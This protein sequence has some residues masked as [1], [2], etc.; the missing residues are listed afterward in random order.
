M[1]DCYELA[2]I[3]PA[4]TDKEERWPMIAK[5]VDDRLADTAHEKAAKGPLRTGDHP[6]DS[7]YRRRCRQ[8]AAARLARRQPPLDARLTAMDAETNRG[9]RGAATEKKNTD[10]IRREPPLL[11]LTARRLQGCIDPRAAGRKRKDCRYPR[12]RHEADRP[13]RAAATILRLRSRRACPNCLR[14]L[15]ARPGEPAPLLLARP[16]LAWLLL[17]TLR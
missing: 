4:V 9:R 1:L 17:T 11:A 10:G 14:P 8:G 7:A 15:S 6:T 12:C 2:S 5:T 16:Q 13:Q 3:L